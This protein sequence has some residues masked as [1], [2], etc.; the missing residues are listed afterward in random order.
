M[1]KPEMLI[2]SDETGIDKRSA[3]RRF[4]YAIKGY[5]AQCQWIQC[6]GKRIS[7]IAAISIHG[8]LAYCT[9]GH[10]NEQHFYHFI[11]CILPKLLP[12]NDNNHNSV[13]V[14]DN[15]PIRHITDVINRIHSVGAL[16]CFIPPLFTT[17]N[18]LWA[19]YFIIFGLTVEHHLGADSKHATTFQAPMTW[20]S[21]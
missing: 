6:R 19:S 13:I 21:M 8:L 9:V 3:K 18:K 2:F 7:T 17:V 10:V 12:F 11:E 15:A 5:P 1:Y 14:L 20:V 16:V 4:G